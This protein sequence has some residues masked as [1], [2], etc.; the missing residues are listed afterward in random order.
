[1]VVGFTTLKMGCVLVMITGD[2]VG[3]LDQA[4]A[5]AAVPNVALR[6]VAAIYIVDI[7]DKL[8]FGT[9]AAFAHER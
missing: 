7:A 1:M 5:F 4:I 8:D 6:D 2:Q 3:N 9:F